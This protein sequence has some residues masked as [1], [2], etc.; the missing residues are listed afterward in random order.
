MLKI[1]TSIKIINLELKK[2]KKKKNLKYNKIL[3][4]KNLSL[5]RIKIISENFELFKNKESWEV[6]EQATIAKLEDTS[7]I[8]KNFK[9]FKPL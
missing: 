3:W 6:N 1:R 7:D 4:A 2:K 5:S 9:N 8:F